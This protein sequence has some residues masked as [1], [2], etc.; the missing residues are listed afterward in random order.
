MN[1]ILI[2]VMAASL[3]IGMNLLF[4]MTG[5]VQ[6]SETYKQVEASQYQVGLTA[7]TLLYGMVAP[8]V[9]EF[10]F[11]FG[12]FR[13]IRKYRNFLI[14]AFVSSL[15]FG[16]Y[17]GNVVQGLYAF[18]MGM[19]IALCYEVE[20]SFLAP[21]FFHMISNLLSLH[22]TY[23]GWFCEENCTFLN[24]MTTIGIACVS[25]IFLLKRHKKTRK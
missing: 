16:V 9:E 20:K 7:G 5:I 25:I 1:Y 12:L 18:L 15:V 11:R 19:A 8:I 21:L 17:H 10:V 23:I 14:A 6:I 2:A 24:C 3:T 22:L 13:W 4:Q